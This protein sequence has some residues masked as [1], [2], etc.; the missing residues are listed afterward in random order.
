MLSAAHTALHSSPLHVSHRVTLTHSFL[1]PAEA[2]KLVITTVDV[3][4][5]EGGTL[6]VSYSCDAIPT[7]VTGDDPYLAAVV[8]LEV[9]FVLCVL[10]NLWEEAREMMQC[11]RI[12]GSALSY[13]DS[14]W[15][16]VDLTSIALQLTGVALW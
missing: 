1:P 15:N 7:S 4:S 12:Y 9:V 8:V 14:G 16:W 5:N 6:T 10:W 2:Q 11:R 13:F 3:G